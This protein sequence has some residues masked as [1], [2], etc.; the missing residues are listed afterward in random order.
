MEAHPSVAGRR[1]RPMISCRRNPP[2]VSTARRVLPISPTPNSSPSAKFGPGNSMQGPITTTASVWLP[3]TP[4]RR[5]SCRQ[6][7][8]PFCRP[9]NPGCSAR[10]CGA[11]QR[12]CWRSS[13]SSSGLRVAFPALS[14]ERATSGASLHFTHVTVTP[15][16]ANGMRVL[17][18]NG[19]IENEQRHDA[20]GASDPCRSR[21]RRTADRKHRHQPAGRRDLWRP[22]PGLLGSRAACRRKNAGGPAFLPAT[23]VT[24]HGLPI[25][26]SQVAPIALIS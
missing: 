9:W 24:G 4:H 21:D 1:A 11:S 17:V 2:T 20:D 23:D 26:A 7:L 18:I 22:E 16:D 5:R 13:C 25:F 10:R 8:L 19:I 3:Q 12:W 14:G 15:R 6:W